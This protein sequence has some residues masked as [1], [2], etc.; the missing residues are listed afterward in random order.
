MVNPTCDVL[1]AGGGIVGLATAVE[2]AL[3]GAQV[4]VL[5]RGQCARAA[6]WAAAGMLAPQAEALP[7]GPLL[8]LALRS[9]SLYA[10]WTAKL[11]TLTGLNTGYWPCGILVPLLAEHQ[12]QLS[13]QER[14]QDW[15]SADAIHQLQ[16]GLSAQVIGGRWLAQEG[17]VDN[18]L[19]AQVLLAAALQLGVDVREQVELEQFQ[20]DGDQVR[21][22]LTTAGEFRADH[23]VLATGAW[24]Y[25]LLKLPVTPRKGQMLALQAPEP[26]FKRVLYGEDIYLVPRQDGRVVVGATNEAVGFTKGNT[27]AGISALLKGATTLFPALAELTIAELWWG[28]RPATPDE[29]PILGPSPWQNLVLATGHY[30]NGI[31]LAPITAQLIA[32]FLQTEAV[33]PLLSAFRWDRF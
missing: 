17:Q 1:I 2:L 4:T 18:R 9:L 13:C 21:Q 24:S 31:L 6:S 16:P 29:A 27:V 12:N 11:E 26:P 25:E 30:R 5:E 32:D 15:L 8:E 28:F 10:D 20:S 7:S 23:Y 14:P 19:L 3:R 33:D 22:L